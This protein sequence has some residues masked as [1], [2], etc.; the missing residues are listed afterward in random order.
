MNQFH[1]SHLRHETGGYSLALASEHRPVELFASDHGARVVFYGV[2]PNEML[3]LANDLIQIAGRIQ[4]REE[5][6][7]HAACSG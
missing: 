2:S 5:Q 7:E 6:D 1:V 3:E 4:D